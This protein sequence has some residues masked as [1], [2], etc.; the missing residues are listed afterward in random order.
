VAD[1]MSTLASDL[2][3]LER[4][5]RLSYLREPDFGFAQTAWEWASGAA[6]DDVL[7]S[8]DIAPGDFVRAVKQVVDALGQV[9]DAAGDGALRDT[10]RTALADLRR[11]VV[12]YASSLE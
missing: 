12:A 11:G 10:A 5:H 3:A 1:A 9:A 6:L 4:E 7:E 2:R 8:A